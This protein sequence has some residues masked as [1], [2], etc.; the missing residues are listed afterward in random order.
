ML[1]ALSHHVRPPAVSRTTLEPSSSPVA[2]HVLSREVTGDVVERVAARVIERAVANASRLEDVVLETIYTER[3]RL[4]HTS[5]DRRSGRDHE[6]LAVLRRD[7]V[8]MRENGGPALVR[9]IVRRYADEVAGDFDPRVYRVATRVLPLALGAIARGQGEGIERALEGNI[10]VQGEVSALR[11][12]A[13]RGTVILAPTHVSNVDSLVMGLVIYRLGLPPFAYGAGLNLYSNRVMAFFMNHLGAYTIDRQK[14][15]PLYRET[16]K[17]FV[18]VLLERGQH[19]LLFPGGTRSRSGAI[20]TRLKKGL[21]GTAPAAFRHALESGSERP[22]IFVVPCTLS[23][24]LVLE[25]PTLIGDFLRAEGGPRYLDAGGEFDSPRRWVEFL[26]GVVGLERGVYVRFSRPLDW[27]GNEVD[28]DGS[29]RDRRGRGVATDAYLRVQGRLA[30]DRARDAEYTRQLGARLIE[31]YHRDHVTVPSQLVAFVL[32]ER[33]REQRVGVDLLRAL[34]GPSF[35]VAVHDILPDIEQACRDLAG[36]EAK[37]AIHAV[38][39]L[40]SLPPQAILQQA[41]ATFASYH[42]A[43]VVEQRGDKLHVLDPELLFY[44]RNRLE[45]YGLLGARDVLD[46][47]GAGQRPWP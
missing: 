35:E 37:G 5:G 36:L 25:A 11:A 7:L 34:R 24:P 3:L 39:G 31:A 44:Y 43:R 13:T 38:A 6:F 28:A 10:H 42:R 23:Y 18:M 12:L 17:E 22:R 33:F 29:S 41:L 20:E 46:S 16:L 47:I 26:R 1:A 30:A 45:G 8:R 21:L 32:F 2:P 4:A 40:S 14:T 15:D 27:L 9:R 19:N